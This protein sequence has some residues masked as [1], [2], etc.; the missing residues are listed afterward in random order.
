MKP[1]EKNERIYKKRVYAGP[2]MYIKA[3]LGCFVKFRKKV[4]NGVQ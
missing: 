4:K 2:K 1:Y 3:E